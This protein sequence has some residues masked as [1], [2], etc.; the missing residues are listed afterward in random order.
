MLAWRVLTV[1][2]ELYS[3]PRTY[4]TIVVLPAAKVELRSLLLLVLRLE[5]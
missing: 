4:R 1:R 2:G 3:E 5:V